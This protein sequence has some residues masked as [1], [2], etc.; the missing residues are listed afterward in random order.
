MPC[1]YFTHFSEG[2]NPAS[3]IDKDLYEVKC[4]IRALI[5]LYTYIN[6]FVEI[7]LCIFVPIFLFAQFT[8]IS[9]NFPVFNLH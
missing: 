9:E 4:H 2:A 7:A 6:R 3:S 1:D 5:D 8:L